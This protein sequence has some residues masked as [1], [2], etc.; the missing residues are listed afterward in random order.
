MVKQRRLLTAIVF[1]LVGCFMYSHSV[2]VHAQA[3]AQGYSSTSSLQIGMM[4]R[5]DPTDTSA[6]DPITQDTASKLLGVVV[7]PNDVPASLSQDGSTG[8]QYY[9]ATSGTYQVLVSD[10]NGT[11]H[12]GDYIVASSLSGVG[13]DQDSVQP[14]VVGIATTSF[15]GKSSGVIGTATLKNSNGKTTT[16]QLG[17][18]TVTIKV[19]GNPQIRQ[20]TTIATGLPSFLQKASQSIVNKPVSYTRAYISFGVLIVSAIIAGSVLYAGVRNGMIA[21]GRNPL[22]RKSIMH[23][24]LEVIFTSLIIFVI[25]IFGVYLLLKL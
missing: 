17:Y 25:G 20:T 22:A 18:V 12:S 23:N 24:L 15:S 1:L 2:N 21:V 13:M 19:A 5:V 11:I 9:V 10:Q 8:Q 16:V 6:V 4:V 14:T 3:V 7:S